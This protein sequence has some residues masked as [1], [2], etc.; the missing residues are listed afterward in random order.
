MKA[1]KQVEQAIDESKDGI[2]I[3][4]RNIP[5]KEFLLN[6]E[7]EKAKQINYVVF[8]SNRGGYNVYA[9]PLEIG[10]FENRKTLPQSWRGKRDKELQEITGVKTARFCHNAGFLC[11]SETMEDA[12]TLAYK[13]I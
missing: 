6:S 13:A 12:I 11:C 4:E 3:L 2:M 10:S 7:Q 8:P 9:V 1:K 5:W